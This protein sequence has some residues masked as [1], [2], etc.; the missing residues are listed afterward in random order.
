M[1]AL[2][3][4]TCTIRSIVF[5]IQCVTVAIRIRRIRVSVA[6]LGF[7]EIVTHGAIAQTVRVAATAA[8]VAASTRS[9]VAAAFACRR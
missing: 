8:A 1:C 6:G 5:G 2:L 9:T 4:C 3:L 7:N